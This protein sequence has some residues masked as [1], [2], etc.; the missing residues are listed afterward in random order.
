MADESTLDLAE[1]LSG[2]RGISP[3]RAAAFVEAATVCLKGEG[4]RS[5]VHLRIAESE[6]GFALTW[7]V[8]SERA[9]FSWRDAEEATED[10][11]TAIALLLVR[12]LT[13]F[14]V[15]ERSVKGTGID[16][17]LGYD[18]PLPFARSARLEVSGI[19]RAERSAFDRRVREKR[20]QTDRSAGELPAY[21]AVTE[22]GTPLSALVH[23]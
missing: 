3:A 2:L 11:A 8:A 15:I 6:H 12:R 14:T 23:R 7:P 18:D 13:D 16:Y 19:R 9:P 17:W 22:F 4:H 10:G 21:I 5:G 20:Q 1:L